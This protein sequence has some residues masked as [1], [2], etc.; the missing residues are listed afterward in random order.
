MSDLGSTGGRS[1]D[2]YP[3]GVTKGEISCSDVAMMAR[4]RVFTK[5]EID[6]K[7][8]DDKAMLSLILNLGELRVEVCELEYTCHIFGQ[9]S[10]PCVH[11][12]T[13][14]L[15]PSRQEPQARLQHLC[16]GGR[17]SRCEMSSARKHTSDTCKRKRCL[18][19]SSRALSGQLQ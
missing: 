16:G 19:R 18:D 17:S 3:T 9:P 1:G 5:C 8:H 4:T 7:W 15:V 14:N 6:P 10:I 12:M 2:V 13:S 11:N